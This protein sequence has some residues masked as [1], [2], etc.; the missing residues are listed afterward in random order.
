MI[1]SHRSRQL[2]LSVLLSLVPATAIAD[3]LILHEGKTLH[4]KIVSEDA[5]EIMIRLANNMFLKVDKSKIKKIV[6]QEQPKRPTI[7]MQTIQTS[8]ATA[9][10]TAPAQATA[11]APDKPA[12]PPVVVMSKSGPKNIPASSTSKQQDK[13]GATF[14]ETF[15]VQT[16]PV[17][18]KNF[19]EVRNNIMAREGGKGILEKGRRMPSETKLVFTWDGKTKAEGGKT[20][21]ASL[22]ITATTTTK[23]PEW[24]APPS[25]DEAS[26]K[27]WD[28]FIT[29]LEEHDKGHADLYQSGLYSLA[30]SLTKLEAANEN[31]LRATSKT[32]MTEWRARIE[33]QQDGHDRRQ[34]KL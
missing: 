24:K 15:H 1:F 19:A 23:L 8:T 12:P 31:A 20:K 21:W 16:Y 17:G 2:I 27:E 26:V 5:E 33:K 29:G 11:P 3:E 28:T 22:V 32:V 25:L 18:G 7:T 34:K 10:K 4:G 6:R 13:F 14:F 30:D 9:V